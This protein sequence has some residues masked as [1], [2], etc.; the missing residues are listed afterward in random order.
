M[1]DTRGGSGLGFIGAA[2]LLGAWLWWHGHL[3]SEWSLFVVTPTG[4]ERQ[5]WGK[6]P[7]PVE[8]AV[9]VG[10]FKNLGTCQGA[11]SVRRTSPL[12][13]GG[14]WFCGLSCDVKE[15][16]P[17][18]TMIRDPSTCRRLEPAPH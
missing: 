10:Q 9:T 16:A 4:M 3:F 8:G 5:A 14:A 6:D 7:T 17:D 15:V 13:E 2:L 11:A 12:V 18:G 1:S